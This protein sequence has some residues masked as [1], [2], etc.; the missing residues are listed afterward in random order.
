M[1]T[2]QLMTSTQ[3]IQDNIN[4]IIDA[5]PLSALFNF[6]LPRTK[7]LPPPPPSPSPP[8]PSKPKVSKKKRAPKTTE[9]SPLDTSPGFHAPRT[10]RALAAV[11]A[12]EAEAGVEPEP[13]TIADLEPGTTLNSE[14]VSEPPKKRRR[15]STMPGQVDSPPMVTDVDSQGLFKMFDAGWILPAGQRRGGRQPVERVPPLPKKKKTGKSF[16]Y[17]M[18]SAD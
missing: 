9:P 16:C 6:E 10:R 14:A 7:P 1:Q 17:V 18:F 12:F 3:D 11:A 5:D 2:L 13:H 4:L 8:P 15:T